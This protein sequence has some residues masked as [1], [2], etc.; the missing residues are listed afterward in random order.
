MAAIRSAAWSRIPA[1]TAACRAAIT[2]QALKDAGLRSP[3]QLLK[4][5]EFNPMGG[6]RIVRD[7]LWFYV[8][9]RESYA[10][11]TIPGMFF[12]KNGG[13]PTQVAR[14]FRH[15]PAGVQRHAREEPHRPR[16]VAGVAAQQDQLHG[17]GAVQL[18][19]PNGRRLRDA[20]AGSAGAEPLYARAH[21]DARVELAPHQQDAAW[22]RAGAA[23]WRTTRTTRRASTA[24]TTTR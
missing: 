8:T 17:L 20:D 6:G 7:R 19:Q 16:H 21:P 15:Q 3:A 14:R 2:P 1:P 18:G 5:W 23:T 10:E 4:V 9:Y 11:N 12:N 24:C 13:D 22:R